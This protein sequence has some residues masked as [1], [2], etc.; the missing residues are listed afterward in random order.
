M[1]ATVAVVALCVAG[2]RTHQ[3]R[4]SATNLDVTLVI[5]GGTAALTGIPFVI[6]SQ[7]ALAKA[8]WWYNAALPR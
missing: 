2:F 6:R 3:F 5:A 1:L 8:V 7:R 4:S